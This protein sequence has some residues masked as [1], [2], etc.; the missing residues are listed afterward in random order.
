MSGAAEES[1]TGE[2]DPVAEAGEAAATLRERYDE[3]RRLEERI[4]DLGRERVEAAADTYRRAHRVLDQYE[5][6]AVGSGDFAAYVQFEG[7]FA[8]AVD[9]GDDALAADAFAAAD[10]AVD[11]KRLSK[12]DFEAA[13][14]ALDP[15]GEYVDLLADRD[16]AVDDYR[17]ARKDARAARKALAARLDELREVAEMADS[18]RAMQLKEHTGN[19]PNVYYL[20]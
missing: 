11:K 8:N 7:E 3:L 13:R 4:A 12:S 20:K 9:V 2:T 15:A 18:T 10:E 1:K 17:A 5:E 6:D 14:E 19:D 16:E